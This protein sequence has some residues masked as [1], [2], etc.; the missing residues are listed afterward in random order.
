[1]KTH[2]L[3]DKGLERQEN[4]DCYYT[5]ELPVGNLPNLFI[6]ADGMG[7]HAGGKLASET[8]MKSFVKSVQKSTLE[9]PDEILTNA[10]KKA[11]DDVIKKAKKVELEGMGTTLVA[12]TIIDGELHVANVGDSR[13]Y[14]ITAAE[15]KQ[16]TKDHSL[17]EEMVRMGEL[18]PSKARTHEKKN[19][20]TRAIGVADEVKADIF[21]VKLKEEQTILLCTD[22]LT[23]MVTDDSIR[24]V[25]VSQRDVI[26]KAE[27]LIIEANKNGGKDN[28]TV[29]VIE[30]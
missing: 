25:I 2:A 19:V 15:V 30:P 17:V 3:T 20:I 22:G 8:A 11:N 29:V 10:V 24:K 1:M 12:A 27:T 28:I 14:L 6:V 7:G 13:L 16:I 4:Q 23:N 5:S 21:K 9:D 18:E 26:E